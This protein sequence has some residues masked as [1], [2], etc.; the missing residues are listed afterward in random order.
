MHL[1]AERGII[2]LDR[3]NDAHYREQGLVPI[4]TD[5]SYFISQ[6]K[7]R[8]ESGEHFLPDDIYKLA[9]LSLNIV[10]MEHRRLHKRYNCYD[11]P[12]VTICAC[13]QDGLMHGFERMLALRNT[14]LYSH[15]CEILRVFSPYKKIRKEQLR[16]KR[17]EDVAYIDGYTNALTWI[18]LKPEERKDAPLPIYYAFGVDEDLITFED[19]K[20]VTPKLPALHKAAYKRAQ[21]MVREQ[22]TYGTS[23]EFHHMPWPL[24]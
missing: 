9:S 3:K 14:G 4:F 21:R 15:K 20:K 24:T 6:I 7:K 17:Y 8:A 19:Y 2:T 22:T 5:G 1:N 10:L 11:N 12:E 18:L 16:A 13:Y 23:V